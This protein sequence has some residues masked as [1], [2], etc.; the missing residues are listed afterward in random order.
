MLNK[1]KK[2]T[3]VGEV[4][5]AL[6]LNTEITGNIVTQDD[7][8][9][10]GSIKGDISSEKKIVIGDRAVI[11]GNIRCANLDSLGQITGDVFCQ[12]KI[13]LRANS[14]FKGNVSTKSIEIEPGAFF[15]GTCQMHE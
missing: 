14:R 6:S 12:E 2:Q 4:H 1:T 7:M 13:I 3:D 11:N 9:F 8:R 15:D 10:D 5:N